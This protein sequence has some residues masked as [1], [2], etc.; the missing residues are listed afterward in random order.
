[1]KM[2]RGQTFLLPSGKVLLAGG[3]NNAGPTVTKTEVYAPAQVE[4]STNTI[5]SPDPSVIGAQVTYTATVSP[6]PSGGTVSFTHN[7]SP[8]AGVGG[9]P[10]DATTGEAVCDVTYASGGTHTIT[11]AYSG[12]A[13]DAGSTSAPLTQVV[14]PA[15]PSGTKANF[16]WHYTANGNAAGWSG[17][18]TS[19]SPAPSAWDRRPWTA[20]CTSP[21]A[22]PCRPGMTS[23]CPATTTR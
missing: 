5:S 10:V 8:I 11:A 4:T 13:S 7:G 15:C 23:P 20:T 12:D 3:Y 16:R 14:V 19:T 17:T 9:Q 18:A 22:P 2:I 21:P 1:M 6:A